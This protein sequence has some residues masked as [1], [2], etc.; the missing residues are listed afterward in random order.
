MSTTPSVWIF[1]G[2][3]HLYIYVQQLGSTDKK[4][5]HSS[6]FWLLSGGGL[7]EFFKKG[8]FVTKILQS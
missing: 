4:L 1:S 8:K 3:P 6:H 7:S 5:H 2:I